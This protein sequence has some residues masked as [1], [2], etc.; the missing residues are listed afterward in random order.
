MGADESWPV[1]ADEGG[2]VGAD[3][4]G[5]VGADEGWPVGAD[6]GGPVYADTQWVLSGE[7]TPLGQELQVSVTF[8][9][10][11]MVPRAISAMQFCNEELTRRAEGAEFSCCVVVPWGTRQW[12]QSKLLPEG[13]GLSGLAGTGCSQVCR[14]SL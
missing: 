3:E 14:L 1:G 4:G 6:E 8:K 12:D 10:G 2:P 9:L 7:D 5:P 11:W 13:G